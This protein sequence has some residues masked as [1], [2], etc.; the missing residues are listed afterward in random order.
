MPWQKKYLWTRTWGAETGLD[1]KPH[2]DFMGW[3][4]GVQ[5]GRIYLDRQTLHK[6]MW[7]WAIQYP[8]GGKPWLPNAGWLDSASEAAQHIEE[9]WEKQKARL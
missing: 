6:G 3:D 5:I 2:E 4:D 8:K 9:T 1:G 7:R